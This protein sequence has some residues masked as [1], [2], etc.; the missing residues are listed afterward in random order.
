MYSALA[1]KKV[2]CCLCSWR[3]LCLLS[4]LLPVTSMSQQLPLSPSRPG[5][6]GTGAVL[7]VSHV[8][9][10]HASLDAANTCHPQSACLQVSTGKHCVQWL[11]DY[12]IEAAT[13]AADQSWAQA[14]AGHAELTAA[15]MLRQGAHALYGACSPLEVRHA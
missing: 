12:I 3:L 9:K 11:A 7:L 6:L 2:C 10:K 15:A 13:P 8:I 5:R 1:D 14:E 4:T